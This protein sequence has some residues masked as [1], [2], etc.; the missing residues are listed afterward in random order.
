[1][2]FWSYGTFFKFGSACVTLKYPSMMQPNT[3]D[4]DFR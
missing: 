1:M 4:N 2:I 3:F